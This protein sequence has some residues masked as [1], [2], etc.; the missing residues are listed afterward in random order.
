MKWRPS[1]VGYI[2]IQKRW[3]PYMSVDRN[4]SNSSHNRN[5]RA[6]IFQNLL[7]SS[8]HVGM[9]ENAVRGDSGG[10]RLIAVCPG[11]RP[12][13]HGALRREKGRFECMHGISPGHHH[14]GRSRLQLGCTYPGGII[15]LLRVFSMVLLGWYRGQFPWFPELS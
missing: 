1:K 13:T 12:K 7:G 9:A 2:W 14:R 10:E 5:R 15:A 4:M 8:F 3:A 11:Q 6:A